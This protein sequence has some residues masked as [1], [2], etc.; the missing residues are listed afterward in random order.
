MTHPNPTAFSADTVPALRMTTAALIGHIHD[1]V[2]VEQLLRVATIKRDAAAAERAAYQDD[3]DA[4]TRRLAQL[5][6][7]RL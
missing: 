5:K 7:G 4:L 1:P 3:V 6:E 2:H